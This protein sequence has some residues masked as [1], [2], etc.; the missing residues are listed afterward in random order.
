MYVQMSMWQSQVENINYS[1]DPSISNFDPSWTA[2]TEHTRNR[3]ASVTHCLKDFRRSWQCKTILSKQTSW[4]LNFWYI[5]KQHWTINCSC[6]H[7]EQKWTGEQNGT[8]LFK[9]KGMKMSWW[10]CFLPPTVD[11]RQF[12]SVLSALLLVYSLGFVYTKL[13]FYNCAFRQLDHA[14][15]VIA[16]VRR[17]G[18]PAHYPQP[19]R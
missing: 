6:M 11:I 10:H 1:I 19:G 4:L 7:A 5:G 15:K 2:I 12:N 8:I 13:Q 3:R 16:V 17:C 14:H 9:R 18:S